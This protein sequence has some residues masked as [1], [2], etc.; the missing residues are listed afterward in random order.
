MTQAHDSPR[1]EKSLIW[2]RLM[3]TVFELI[4]VAFAL[5]V[6][7]CHSVMMAGHSSTSYYI[8][9]GHDS[10]SMGCLQSCNGM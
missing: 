8:R 4:R 2:F 3:P 6:T 7:E 5:I 9:R 1:K 10:I